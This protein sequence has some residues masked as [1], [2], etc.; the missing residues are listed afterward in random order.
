MH[1]IKPLGGKRRSVKQ[2]R[3][4]TDFR[5]Q[6]RVVA[7][8]LDL[9]NHIPRDPQFPITEEFLVRLEKCLAPEVREHFRPLRASMRK[10]VE[11]ADKQPPEH[12]PLKYHA[13]A[14]ARTLDAM[15]R[16]LADAIF[17]G[18]CERADLSAGIRHGERIRPYGNTRLVEVLHQVSVDHKGQVRIRYINLLS[19]FEEVWHQLTP[20]RI[21]YCDRP[22][23][24]ALFYA[25][26]DDGRWCSEDCGELARHPPKSKRPDTQLAE[27]QP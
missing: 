17:N 9:A 26:R 11:F 27:I 4:R 13:G 24:G 14:M 10:V 21:R 25:T 23:C 1:K 18:L 19:A 6:S 5:E 16:Q 3:T 15:L 8:F 22:E 20:G 7:P 12:G 2:Q